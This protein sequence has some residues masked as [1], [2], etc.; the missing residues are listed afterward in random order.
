MPA[1]RGIAVSPVSTQHLAGGEVVLLHLRQN[2]AL[3][4]DVAQELAATA[5]AT[6]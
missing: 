1:T 5:F 6:R 4:A 2:A 3:A